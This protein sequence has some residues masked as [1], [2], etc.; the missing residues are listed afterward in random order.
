MWWYVFVFY[1][2]I[3]C[4]Q[5][6]IRSLQPF[7]NDFPRADIHEMISPDLLHQIIKGVFKDHL[8]TWV[9]EYLVIE[10]GKAEAGRIMDD[11]DRRYDLSSSY[12]SL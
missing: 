2:E 3:M 9:G 6:L 10:H 4:R 12:S 1:L 7:T 11:I 8:V 5:K